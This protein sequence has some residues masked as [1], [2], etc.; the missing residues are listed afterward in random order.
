MASETIKGEKEEVMK[1]QCPECTKDIPP[2][3][4]LCEK[5]SE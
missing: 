4:D 5:C 1:Y 3:E 2:W